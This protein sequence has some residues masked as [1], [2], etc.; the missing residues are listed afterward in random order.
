MPT[1]HGSGQAWY[2][3]RNVS[4]LRRFWLRDDGNQY[5]IGRMRSQQPRPV[6]HG[7]GKEISESAQLVGSGREEERHEVEVNIPAGW[8]D[9]QQCGCKPG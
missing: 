9:G 5:T 4:Q 2:Q 6:C 8:D 7:T 1:R 3:S